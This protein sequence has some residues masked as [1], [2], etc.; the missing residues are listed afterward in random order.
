MPQP[1][2]AVPGQATLSEVPGTELKLLLATFD[3]FPEFV[4]RYSPWLSD[5]CIFVE[6]REAVPV[7][8]P[9]RLE[10]RLRDRPALVR[11]LGEVGWVRPASAGDG[12]PGV[13]IDVTYL[14]P[15]S[16]CLIESIFRLVIG[17]R[18]TATRSQR[19]TLDEPGA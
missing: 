15:A 7:G 18:G 16:A 6:T 3:S 2:P 17:R 12:P 8:T 4:A 19:A 14:D 5:S 10:I 1:S 11:A 9:V 13:A